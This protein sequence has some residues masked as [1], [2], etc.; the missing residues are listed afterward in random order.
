MVKWVDGF[1]CEDDVVVSTRIRLARNL[2]DY[3]FPQK[4][5]MEESEKLTQDILNVMKDI[6]GN[7]NYKFIRINNLTPIERVVYI[8]EHLISPG[9]IQRP[10]YSSFLLR[11]DENITIMINE[12]DHLRIQALLPGLNFGKAWQIISEV[13][14]FL[15]SF[16]DYAFHQEFGYLTACPTNTGT[17]LRASVMVHL[18]SLTATGHINNFINS[19]NKIG[20]AVRGIY[21]EGTETVGNL[22][23][24]SNQMTLGQGEEEIIRILENIVNQI[25]E[26]E[27]NARRNLIENRKYEV[28]DRVFRSLGILKHSRMISSKEAMGLLSNVRLGIEMGIIDDIELKK[29][30][31]LMIT[32]QPAYI[33]NYASKELTENERNIV[34][35]SYIRERL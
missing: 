6:T 11:D 13:D 33:Q 7:M 8:E 1:A 15:E 19:L 18:P 27:R 23:Q 12:E 21:G 14:D 16:L 35:A 30:D 10:D 4:M 22:F 34:R 32:I 26:R 5:N 31:K 25:L 3:R 20:L 17:G 29:I 2:K 24:I 9:L 28:E